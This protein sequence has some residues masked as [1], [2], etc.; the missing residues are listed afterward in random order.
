MHKSIIQ[1]IILALVALTLG[2]ADALA[3]SVSVFASG[4]QAPTKIIST[5]GGNLLV[6]E[7][8]TGPNTGCISFINHGGVRRT[9]VAGLP[10]G[11]NTAAG[12]AEPSGPSGLALRGRT[13]YVTI[14]AG[15]EVL[16][17]PVPGSEVVN[18]NPSSNFL[19][20]LLA[21]NFNSQID[22][23]TGGF[24]LTAADQ[25]SLLVKP[26]VELTSATGEIASIEV[27]ANFPNFENN[28][29]PG[30]QGIER[31]SNPFGVVL[32]GNTIYAVDASLN[33]VWKLGRKRREF[34]VLYRFGPKPNPLPFG[35][36]VSAPV[37]DSIRLMGNQLLVPF[38]PGAS[39]IHKINLADNGASTFIRGLAATIA[40][41]A[42]CL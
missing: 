26:A 22:N 23:V 38:P 4:L 42:Q 3:Q 25:A 5:P 24:T 16:A 10:S 36:P 12:G 2:S 31:A 19:S 13:L 7:S 21:I 30:F 28:P 37:P 8:G 17:G 32:K 39:E 20:S 9:L 33:L 40:V 14:G 35:P 11:I 41:G 6:A 15:D 34:R 29:I 18:P 27:V 1:L